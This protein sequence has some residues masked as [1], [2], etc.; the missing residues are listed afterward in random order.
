[1]IR[2]NLR[3]LFKVLIG[4]YILIATC[5]AFGQGQRSAPIHVV[6][7]LD[8]TLLNSTTEVMAQ[9]DPHGVI[10]FQGKLYRLPHGTIESLIR[11]HRAGADISLFSGGEVERNN[12]A[13]QYIAAQVNDGLIQLGVRSVFKFAKVLSLPDLLVTSAQPEARF[14]EKFKKELSR[15]FDVS[16]T[17]LV[18]DIKEFIVSGQEKNMVWLGPTYNDRPRFELVNLE[19]V[20]Q[21][22]YSAPDYSEWSRDRL[23]IVV[24]TDNILKAAQ[25]MRDKKISLPEAYYQVDPFKLKFPMC[26]NLF[27]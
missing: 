20:A 2:Y 10:E 6:F 22:K 3:D 24:A 11:L 7:D 27:L 9:A 8:W 19:D 26:G 25:L 21:K 23:K 13:A 17:L 1:M 5:L 4:L 16:K 15:F 18:D 14:A 12:F